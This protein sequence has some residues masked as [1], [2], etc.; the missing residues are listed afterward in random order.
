MSVLRGGVAG[1]VRRRNVVGE[2]TFEIRCEHAAYVAGEADQVV[3]VD[4]V[5]VQRPGRHGRVEPQ[6]VIGAEEVTCLLGLGGETPS[7]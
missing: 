3:G 4:F 6:D 7:E 2:V 5:E 1:N